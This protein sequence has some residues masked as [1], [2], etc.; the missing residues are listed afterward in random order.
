VFESLKKMLGVGTPPPPPTNH[1]ER[2][3][4]AFFAAARADLE[5]L[6]TQAM[7]SE[8]AAALL[9]ATTADKVYAFGAALRYFERLKQELLERRSSASSNEFLAVEQLLAAFNRQGLEVTADELAVLLAQQAEHPLG[10]LVITPQFEPVVRLA[11]SAVRRGVVLTDRARRSLEQLERLCES[12]GWTQVKKLAPRIR[13]LLVRPGEIQVFD[14]ICDWVRAISTEVAALPAAERDAW[15]AL[16]AHAGTASSA[17]P[18]RKFLTVAASFVEPIGAAAVSAA[19]ERWFETVRAEDP[20]SRPLASEIN[21]KT[22]SGLVWLSALPALAKVAPAVVEL[23]LYAFRKVPTVGAIS[24][25]VGNACIAALSEA[26]PI[27]A[28]R[29]LDTLRVRIRYPSARK[30]IET[31]LAA[32]SARSGVDRAALEDLSVPTHELSAALDRT[33]PVGPGS[34]RLAIATDGEVSVTWF[35]AD[36]ASRATVPARL[37]REAA[38]AV[39]LVRREA[40]SI[41]QTLATQT[42]RLERSFVEE[43]RWDVPDFQRHVL[44]HP[45]R[46]HL[47]RR[48]IW[49]LT[50]GADQRAL[51]PDAAGWLDAAGEP[52][53]EPGPHA[54]V[55]LWHP[56][57]STAAEVLAWRRSIER[58][59]VVQPFKQAHRE[60]YVLTDAE[61]ATATYSNRFAAHIVKQHQLAALCQSRGWTYRLQ[62]AFDSINAPKCQLPRDAGVAELLVD[63][64][65]GGTQSDA[66]IY[67]YVTTD[68][69]RVWRGGEPMAL[70]EMEPRLLSEVMRDVDL[71][72]GVASVG[73]DPTWRDSGP[74]AH[75]VYWDGFAFGEL[76]QAG[77]T[78]REQLA[79]IIPGLRV[80]DRLSMDGRFLVVRGDLRTYKIHLGSA[81]VLMEP[82]DQY[83]CIVQGA[84][85]GERVYLPFDGDSVLPLILSKALLLADDTHIT[86]RVILSQ[87]RRS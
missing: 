52:A 72:V 61:R 42:A 35:D 85:G 7:A 22:L 73:N 75:R 8:A 87:F 74:D 54:T 44:A 51:M 2:W 83:L 13:M 55:T 50:E 15:M 47:A 64:T 29:H 43:R 16:I 53:P 5:R 40:K 24:T 38:P 86:D 71:F 4:D 1:V 49:G 32:V 60:I 25:R 70:A 20:A 12:H 21:S 65:A 79:R 81:N 80:A 26:E 18:S 77:E 10:P 45:L 34:A 28:V 63:S 6:P 37:K 76:T 3:L 19:L 41:A 39:A 48:L 33:M 36:G 67:L 11:E 84:F 69:V 23:A 66:G 78:R 17:R 56:I 14:P 9:G 58:R 57:D 27:D 59:G 68:Q 46:A 30:L 82:N 31:A 62:G